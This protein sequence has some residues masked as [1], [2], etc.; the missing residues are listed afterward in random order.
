MEVQVERVALGEPGRDGGLV[1]RG[2]ERGLPG[3]LEPVGVGGQ[4]GCLRQGREPGEQGGSGVGG[5][6]AGVGDPPGRC[7]LQCQQRQDVRQG[8]DLRGGRVARG[9]HQVRDAE[10]DQVRNG[11][12]QPGQPGLG[13]AGLRGEVRRFGAGLDL[14]G[15]PAAVGVGAAPHPGQ[16]LLGDHL[17]DPGPVQRDALGRERGGDL[18][19]GVPGGAQLDD[20]RPCG[21]L[22]R[23][24]LRA[25]P[26][27]DEELPAAGTEVPH[28]RQQARGGVA[29][30]GSGLGRG[31]PL[32]QVGAQRLIP[33]VRR[34]GR[35]QEELPAGPGRLRVFR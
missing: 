5:D 29:E 3:M 31:Q 33:A 17:G 8:G 16:S 19:D 13:Q 1:Q 10:R 25:G 21:V 12:E 35:A 30:P 22:G 4:R 6:V 15:R 26:A 18:V 9:G 2:Q 24:G 11:Q 20:P 32:G 7:Q 27:G 34:G 28:R 14:P 23:R